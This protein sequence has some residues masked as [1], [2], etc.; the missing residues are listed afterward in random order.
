M[1]VLQRTNGFTDDR[2]IISGKADLQFCGKL[3]REAIS[4]DFLIGML[5]ILA[6]SRRTLFSRFNIINY[7]F[8][9]FYDKNRPA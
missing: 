6:C 1:T 5:H 2:Q 9:Y 8:L 7:K 4:F 3:K